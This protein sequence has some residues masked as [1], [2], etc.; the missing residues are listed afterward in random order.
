MM[1]RSIFL[2]YGRSKSKRGNHKK[3]D[4]KY[5]KWWEDFKSGLIIQ[6]GQHLTPFFVQKTVENWLNQVFCSFS[7]VFFAKKY[8]SNVVR[9]KFW[10]QIWNPHHLRYFRPPIVMIYTFWFFDLYAFSKIQV[11]LA[12][13]NFLNWYFEG[14]FEISAPKYSI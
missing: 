14:E 10:G 11:D 12:I 2:M 1:A 7:T 9:F 13:I 5:S 6:I 3:W 4:L 8:S